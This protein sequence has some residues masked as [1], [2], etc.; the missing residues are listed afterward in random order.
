MY[1]RLRVF[2]VIFMLLSYVMLAGCTYTVGQPTP[3][4]LSNLPWYEQFKYWTPE[5]RANFSY[6]FWKIQK[7][8]YDRWNALENKPPELIAYLKAKRELVDKAR[9]PLEIYLISVKNGT[10]ASLQEKE[11]LDLLTQ[12]QLLILEKT[13]G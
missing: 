4:N 8:D 2:S 5:Q 11:V 13:G 1:R 9:L 12:L 3:E 10:P 7:D 6:D